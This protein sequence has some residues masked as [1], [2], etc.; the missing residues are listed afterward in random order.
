MAMKMTPEMHMEVIDFINSTTAEQHLF[1]IKCLADKIS[2]NLRTSE[3]IKCYNIEEPFSQINF[4]GMMIDIN[5]Y[6]D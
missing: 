1:F 2:I 5:T 4:N 6:E 3:G